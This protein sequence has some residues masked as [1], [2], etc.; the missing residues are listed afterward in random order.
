MNNS[1]CLHDEVSIKISIVGLGFGTFWVGEHICMLGG[2]C[3][4]TLHGQKILNLG[5]CWAL[6]HVSLPL[7][8][9]LCPLSHLLQILVYLAVP[10]RGPQHPCLSVWGL[11]WHV[12]SSCRAQAP[13]LQLVG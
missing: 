9:H 11:S 6:P 10:G 13:W 3:I 7:S 4:P 2:W 5:P 1:S 12:D 8:L